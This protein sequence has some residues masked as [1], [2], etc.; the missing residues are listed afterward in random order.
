MRATTGVCVFGGI[1]AFLLITCS[2]V[3]RPSA[4]DADTFPDPKR[5]VNLCGRKGKKSNICDPDG[6]LTLA[7][8]N[9]IEGVLKDVWEGADPYVRAPC[10]S[11]GVIGYQ[12]AVAVMRRMKVHKGED[13]AAAAH[14]IAK[15]LHAKWG[16]GAAACD[17]GVLL[18]LAVDDRQ[19][20][21][22]TGQGAQKSL[23][24]NSIGG[25][26]GHMRGA[27]RKGDYDAAVEE[28]V[29]DIGLGLAGRPPAG[30]EWEWF[31]LIFFGAIGAFL[32]HSCW[33]GMR[34]RRQYRNCRDA[35]K[36][37]KDEQHKLR[38]RE[39][40]R[41]RTCPVCLEEFAGD[42]DAPSA[43]PPPQGPS[44]AD[45]DD[46]PSAPLLPAENG[47]SSSKIKDEGEPSSSTSPAGGAAVSGLRRRGSGRMDDAETGGGWKATAA[48]GSP[49]AERVPVTLRCGHTFCEPCLTQWMER[50]ATCPIC[51]E[52]VDGDQDAAARG[53]ASS[54]Q[55]AVRPRYMT[56][57][58]LTAELAFRLMTLQ[59]RYPAFITPSL[60]DRWSAEARDT[61][62]FD[63]EGAREFLLSD[64]AVRAQHEMSGRAGNT[65]S[66]G[67]GSGSGGGGGGGSW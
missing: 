14:R 16:V 32:L 57:D 60:V 31:P 58:L 55:G 38:T 42:P 48:G 43:P 36:K 52:R 6:V 50:A 9:R 21:I 61:G 24:D 1:T 51:R 53:A 20:Y 13:A 40:S 15:A 44:S 5:D 2:A 64:P 33:K 11:A 66:F 59:H 37:V 56:D 34:Q 3:E 22:S 49:G 8:A 17:N 67:G 4:W 26:V 18:L 12:V 35:L 47:S 10:G 29:V 25:I 27:L 39:W 7:G 45:A 46:G 41:P 54:V 30:S 63:F 65:M 62:N 23:P 28:A 19:V